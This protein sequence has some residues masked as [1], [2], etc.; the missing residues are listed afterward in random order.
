MKKILVIMLLLISFGMAQAQK[1]SGVEKW[2]GFIGKQAC[3]MQ[4]TIYEKS[5]RPGFESEITYK[6]FITI[7]KTKIPITGWFE[8]NTMRFNETIKGKKVYTIYFDLS[9]AE[10]VEGYEMVGK[11]TI[12]G[13]ATRIILKKG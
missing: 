2:K 13:V 4:Y 8:G 12:N 11:R 7:G 5:G 1:A 9:G 3:T 10:E 6:G